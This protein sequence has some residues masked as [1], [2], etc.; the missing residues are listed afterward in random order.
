MCKKIAASQK[1]WQ[2]FPAE[3]KC[4]RF[5]AKMFKSKKI[6]TMLWQKIRA[7]KNCH[8]VV[9]EISSREKMPQ[10]SKANFN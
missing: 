7:E 10:Q 9:A 6:A 4:H 8:N 5:V 2:N 1:L 3:K